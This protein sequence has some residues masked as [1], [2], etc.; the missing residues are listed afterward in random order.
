MIDFSKLIDINYL[1]DPNPGFD[2]LFLIPFT[3]IFG[4]FLLTGIIFGLIKQ[5]NRSLIIAAVAQ[6]LRWLGALGLILVFARYETL[7][8]LSLRILYYLLALGFLIWLVIIIRK[9]A[10]VTPVSSEQTIRQQTYDKYL[11]RPKRRKR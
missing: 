6:W 11:P 4:L 10:K 1:L 9:A 8:Y 2:F 7:P 3:V 5:L